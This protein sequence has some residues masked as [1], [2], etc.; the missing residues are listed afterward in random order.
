MTDGFLIHMLFHGYL[1]QR[2][3]IV[4]F[5][6][7]DPPFFDPLFLNIGLT[8]LWTDKHALFVQDTALF[9]HGVDTPSCV[10]MAQASVGFQCGL[11]RVLTDFMTA[12]RMRPCGPAG[13]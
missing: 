8:A 4:A 1:G 7:A 9:V 2:P 10:S 6:T 3:P 5:M 11:I 12:D 13:S